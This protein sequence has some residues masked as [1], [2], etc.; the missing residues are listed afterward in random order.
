MITV[1]AAEARV[2]AAGLAA[3]ARPFL[4]GIVGPPGAGKSTFAPSL[5]APVLPMDGFHCA[6]ELLD[7]LGRR[8]RKGAP[9]TFD[10]AGYAALLSRVRAG[11][12][13]IAPRFDRALEAAVAGAIPL[14]G[15][16]R[17]IVTEGNYLLHDGDG[18]ERIRPL[19]DEVWYLDV[20]DE[21]RVRRLVARHESH[22]RSHD[23]AAAWVRR[24]DER[25]AALIASG[26]LR[27]DAVVALDDRDPHSTTARDAGPHPQG[28]RT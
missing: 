10:V 5:G 26:R 18:W 8:E 17:L 20:P 6:D 27:A 11:E 13:V 22:G 4:L 25:N 24:V 1:T 12:D 3:S 15:S 2:R 23:Q 28:S 14:A 19:L 16:A 9:D 21:L 7:A